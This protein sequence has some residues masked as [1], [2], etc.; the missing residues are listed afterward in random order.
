MTEM[1]TALITG[2][3]SGFGAAIARR[4]VRDG[5]RVAVT[6]RRRDRLDALTDELGSDRWLALEFDVRDRHACLEAVRNLPW[7]YAALD[8]FVN[9]AGG[10]R[11]LDSAYKADLDDWDWMVDHIRIYAA[12]LW[13]LCTAPILPFEFV[14]VADQFKARIVE[15]ATAGIS[16]G[17]GS[18]SEHAAALDASARRL[19]EAAKRWDARYRADA[20]LGSGPAEMGLT[21]FV[22]G[23]STFTPRAK[24]LGR[25]G[26][27]SGVEEVRLPTRRGSRVTKPPARRVSTVLST[28]RSQEAAA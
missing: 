26:F 4:L 20:T 1:K 5:F 14:N 19:D 6:G 3:T 2:A 10:A 16:V 24:R 18:L 11:G 28:V 23:R 17:V 22:R 13:D 27:S 21:M 8:V 15:L 12:Y 9:N 7:E 25:R